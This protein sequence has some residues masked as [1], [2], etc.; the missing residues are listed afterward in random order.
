MKISSE[1]FLDS[2][3]KAIVESVGCR[4]TCDV[5]QISSEHVYDTDS[6]HTLAEYF[7]ELIN[8]YTPLNQSKFTPVS[9]NI[10]LAK[11]I[12]SEWNIFSSKCTVDHISFILKGICA[13]KYN[14]TPE[15]FENPVVLE[16][17][18]DPLYKQEH[19]LLKTNTWEDFTKHLIQHNRYHSSDFNTKL[20]KKFCRFII[21]K[22]TVG[23]KFYRARISDKEGFN[24]NQMGCPPYQNSRSGRVN[25]AGIECLYM[26]SDPETPIREVR[27]GRAD[28][29]SLATFELQED[30]WVV[31]FK[32]INKFSPFKLDDSSVTFQEY[33]INKHYLNKIDAEMGKIVRKNDAVLEYIPTQ[34]ICDFIKTVSFSIGDKDIRLSG[35]EYNSTLSNSGYNI[36]L[37]DPALVKGISVEIREVT[38]LTYE[39]KLI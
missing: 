1:C 5:L 16:E 10:T 19:S 21:R 4:G 30:I 34:Y 9:K 12:Y 25:A 6:D 20:F 33:I 7:E 23:T 22:Y 13:N 27:A 35:I 38:D 8:I 3:L 2:E 17:R 32:H 39:T 31:D 26:S 24:I 15:M 37:F 18:Y 29:V 11:E 14:Q 36:A 28:Y